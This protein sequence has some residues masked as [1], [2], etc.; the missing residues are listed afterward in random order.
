VRDLQ[1]EVRQAAEAAEADAT[2]LRAA[3]DIRSA[4]ADDPVGS[5][6]DAAYAR[7]F[8][9][10]EPDVDTLGSDA[11]GARIRARPPGVALAFSAALDDW[12]RQRRTARPKDEASWG[13]LIAAARAVDHDETRD[14]LRAI[15]VL[16]DRKAQRA[17]LL[18]LARQADPR[19]WPPASLM[20]LA[21]SLYAADEH[22]AAI[23]LLRRA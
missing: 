10:A 19:A 21:R 8:R 20:L 14:R 16:A 12:A 4:E 9:E 6:S 1:E 18:E 13:R 22:D 23:D 7:S 15:W 5:V 17:P 3:V 11:A 2:L